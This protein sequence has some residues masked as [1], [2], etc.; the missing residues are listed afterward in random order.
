[1]DGVLRWRANDDVDGGYH[2]NIT[3]TFMIG[4]TLKECQMMEILYVQA[5]V[6]S[7]NERVLNLLVCNA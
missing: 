4:R 2:P 5:I 3:Y 7:L 1:M 6:N